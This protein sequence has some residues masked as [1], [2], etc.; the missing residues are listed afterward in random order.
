M[1]E[2]APGQDA[3]TASAIA[4]SELDPVPN[5][6]PVRRRGSPNPRADH[7]TAMTPHNTTEPRLAQ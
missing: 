1:R 7:A 4:N 5:G 2:V 6:S 3:R